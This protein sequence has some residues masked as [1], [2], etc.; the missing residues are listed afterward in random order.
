YRY[1]ETSAGVTAANQWQHKETF[2]GAF[3]FDEKG[4]YTVQALLDTGSNF[5]ASWDATG[6]GTGDP[7]WDFRVRRLW[8]RAV[9]V[10]G[11]E[12]SAGGLDVLLRDAPRHPSDD[13]T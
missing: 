13:N 5:S 7:T 4:R 12:L 2:K 11:L 1:I 10:D 9:P 3:K 6:V 8:A